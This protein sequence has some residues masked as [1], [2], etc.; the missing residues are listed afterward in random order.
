MTAIK[1]HRWAIALVASLAL[2][3]FLGGVFA[4]NWRLHG[5]GQDTFT[6]NPF[7]VFW[8]REP[9]EEPARATFRRIWTEH[10][11]ELRPRVREMHAARRLVSERLADENFDPEELTRALT[12]LRAATQASQSAMHAALVELTADL[13]PEERRVLAE[14]GMRRHAKHMR[15]RMKGFPP[16]AP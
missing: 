16:P 1:S 3:L 2:N 8:A 11:D 9:L 15:H 12:D 13:T 6:A 5:L 10:A 14:A 4:A 7:A